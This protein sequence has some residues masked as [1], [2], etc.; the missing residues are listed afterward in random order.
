M[1]Q[2]LFKYIFSIFLLIS[3]CSSFSFSQPA[4]EWVQRYNDYANVDK[5]VVD[6]K[7]DK[8]GNIYIAGYIQNNDTSRMFL[9]LKYNSNGNFQWARTYNCMGGWDYAIGLRV[10]TLGNVYVAGRSDTLNA[11][12]N[13][14]ASF[15]II[16]YSGNG[17]TLWKRRFVNE[18]STY[19][20]PKAVCLDD[21]MNVYITGDSYKNLQSSNYTTVKY[22]KDGKFIW[23]RFYDGANGYDVPSSIVYKNNFIYITGGTNSS[24]ANSLKYNLN[25]ELTWITNFITVG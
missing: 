23:S 22:N 21:S 19:A 4:I 9:T 10:D 24:Y 11:L 7:L 17:D 16:K 8:A 20:I 12:Q 3:L 18:D 14:M 25:G 13:V 6:T 2:K 1:K 5:H 15:F